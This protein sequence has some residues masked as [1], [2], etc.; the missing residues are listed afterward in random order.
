MFATK[1]EEYK[2]ELLQEGRQEGREEGRE[3]GK[4]ESARMLKAKGVSV[5][6]I[7]RLLEIDI[8]KVKNL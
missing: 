3:E 5:T 7:A 8:E 4:L 6:E 1:L 2:K